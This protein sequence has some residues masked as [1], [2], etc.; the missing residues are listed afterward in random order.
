MELEKAKTV[1][2]LF[3]EVRDHDLVLT[4]D[5]P[6]AD[7]LNARLEE[8]REGLFAAT[9]RR[10]AFQEQ[11]DVETRREL[12]LEI[13]RETGMSWKQAS[14]L[15]DSVLECWMATGELEAIEKHDR[16]SGEETRQIIDLLKDSENPYR[17]IENYELEADSVAVIAPYRFN[18]LDRKI[19]PEN[20]DEIE[21]FGGETRELPEFNVFSSAT[22]IVQAVIEN[23]DDPEDVAIVLEESSRYQPLVESAL[24]NRGIGYNSEQ[25]FADD[26]DLRT[27]LGLLRLSFSRKRLRL[28]DVQPVLRYL[29]ITV[30]GAQNHAYI[31]ELEDEQLEDFREFLNVVEY[32]SFGEVLEGFEKL[33]ESMLDG[34]R[35]VLEELG[36]E[37]NQVTEADVSR[38][39]YYVDSFDPLKDSSS[40]GVLL[41]SPKSSIFI[42]RETVYYL[43]MDASWTR[44]IDN[45]P[46]TDRERLERKNLKDFKILVQNGSR[47]YFMVQDREFNEE[48]TPCYY[49]NELGEIESFTDHRH[50]R[51]P[52]LESPEFRGFEK[53]DY[54]IEPEEIEVISQ[55]SLNKFVK[56]PRTYYF[57][58][59]VKDPDRVAMKKGNVFHDF[60]EY[61]VNHPEHVEEDLEA[62]VELGL[63]AVKPYADELETGQLETEFRVGMANILEFI[64][65]QE[66]DSS[67]KYDSWGEKNLFAEH[68]DRD[69]TSKVSEAGFHNPEIGGEGKIDLLASDTHLVDYKSSGYVRSRSKVVE[70]SSVELFDDDPDFQ[71]VMYL[72]QHR[73]KVPGKKLKFSYYYF[74]G[75]LGD[76]IT[77]GAGLDDRTVTV[78]YYPEKFQEWVPETETFEML[79]RDVAKSNPRRKTLEKLGLPRYREFFSENSVPHEFDAD[80]L[81]ESEF[82]AEFEKFAKKHVGD[83]RYV[84]RGCKKTLKKLVEFRRENYFKEDLDRFEEFLQEKIDELNRCRRKGFP[85]GD[86]D[87]DE[88]YYTDMMVE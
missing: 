47:Q 84:E 27:F 46:W 26:E 81:L 39:E 74:L 15:L 2:Q 19:L 9:P 53:E 83:Y 48:I 60:A 67:E 22:G 77:S 44:E 68:F 71:P 63:E 11:Q 59:L 32:M 8:P 23:I 62:F 85:M 17:A 78:E 34:I 41:A 31:S 25:S 66:I 87:P 33:T 1:D 55:S 79:I 61:Y 10:L 75:S 16:F 73:E 40:E 80:A 49:F 18:E 51:Y 3:E 30:P 4:T 52:G 5:A 12:F 57:S 37:E 72:T 65:N 82:A 20:Y 7:A 36:L 28:R 54:G 38:L 35:E 14:F 58:R 24:E 56:S 69:I 6:L 50:E 76:D 42:D 70:S 88:T 21:V 43:G 86:V 29:G 64:R 13:V 45:R